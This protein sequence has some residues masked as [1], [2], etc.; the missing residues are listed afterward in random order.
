VLGIVAFYN[1]VRI[2]WGER[3][4]RIS[5]FLALFFPG[6]W[7]YATLG[8]FSH[9]LVVTLILWSLYSYL[10]YKKTPKFYFSALS[11]FL[12]ALALFVRLAIAPWFGGI[13]IVLLFLD[14]YTRRKRMFLFYSVWAIMIGLFFVLPSLLVHQSLF[15]AVLQTGYVL[16]QEGQRSLFVEIFFPGG[17]HPA[18]A[19]KNFYEY[20]IILFW[21]VTI[22]SLL[23][24]LYFFIHLGKARLVERKYLFIS[25]AVSLWLIIYYGSWTL[26]DN[27][28]FNVSIG[29]AYVRYWLPLFLLLI[30]FAVYGY[31]KI[32]TLIKSH[33]ISLVVGGSALLLYVILSAY[34]VFYQFEDSLVPIKKTLAINVQIRDEVIETTEEDAVIVSSR[35]DKVFFPSRDVVHVD[36]LANMSEDVSALIEKRPVY[37]YTIDSNEFIVNEYGFLFNER[38]LELTEVTQLEKGALYALTNK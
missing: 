17:I 11:G 18:T 2:V 22:P 4:A 14:I 7:Y 35:H 6:W 21:Y 16:S 37:V 26:T 23:G 32:N 30:P 34:A 15:G 5:F 38:S 13:W 20:A 9:V 31:T 24:M 19:F 10:L 8:L 29:V 28:N 12:V 3:I 25:V 36:S 27:I 1:C 33:N